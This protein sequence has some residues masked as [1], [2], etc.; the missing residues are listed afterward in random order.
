MN[1]KNAAFFWSEA[2]TSLLRNRILSLATVTTIGICILILGVA[3]LLSVNVGNFMSQLE[4]DVQIRA[5][6]AAHVSTERTVNLKEEIEAID[7]VDEVVY[8]SKE[9][10][11]QQMESKVGQEGYDLTKALGDNPLPDSYI[12]KAKDPENVSAI[13]AKIEELQGVDKVNYGQG[14]VERLFSVSRW[15]RYISFAL[16]VMF[17]FGAIF[18][19]STTI[20]LAIFARRKEV[21]LMKLIGATD[22]FIRWPFFIE[23]ILL[24]SVGSIVAIVVLMTGYESLLGNMQNAIYFIPMVNDSAYLLKFYLMLF[25]TGTSLGI[26]GTYISLNR[27]LDV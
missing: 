1:F 9:D 24:A 27:F 14:T 17:A 20:R 23:G 8:V 12:V 3:V 6:L 26:L 13:A 21:F 22:W 19:I 11:L 4:S 16:I 10:A 15:V 5:F 25:V 2:L 18:L 7:G